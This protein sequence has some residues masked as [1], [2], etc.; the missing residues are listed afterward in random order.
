ME[1]VPP[2]PTEAQPPSEIVTQATPEPATPKP[3]TPKPETPKPQTPKPI[4]PKPAT[5]KPATPKPATPKTTP[6]ATPKKTTPKPGTD[7]TPK[8]KATPGEKTTGTPG[9]KKTDGTATSTNAKPGEGKTGGNGPGDGN[10]K[11]PGKTGNGTGASEY[12]WY[13][14]M[15]HDRF[16]NRWEQPTSIV[17]AGTDYVTTLKIRIA[18]DGTISNREIVHSSGNPVMDESVLA[19]ANKVQQIEPLPAGLGNG[20]SFEIQVNFKLDQGQ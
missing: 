1:L 14:S 5:P 12:G 6:K 20:D 10:G 9:P 11:G 3:A 18:K 7:S 8:A 4:T 17:R 13:F 16:H 15:L 19:A 2:P